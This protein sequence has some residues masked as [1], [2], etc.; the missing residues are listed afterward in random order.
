MTLNCRRCGERLIAGKRFCPACGASADFSCPSCGATI[1]PGFKY[2]PDCGAALGEGSQAPPE[3]RAARKPKRAA[4]GRPAAGGTRRPAQPKER[5]L[6]TVL[7]CDLVGSTAIAERLDPEEYHELLERY[8]A[9]A[10]KEIHRLGGMVT[11]MAGDG[12]M[13]LFG[14]PLAHEDA[15]ERAIRAA[16]SIRDSLQ[17]AGGQR[18]PAAGAG[19]NVRIGIH[20]G[21]VLLGPIGNDLRMDYTAIGDTTNVAARLQSVAEPGTILVSD[22]TERLVRGRFVLERAGDFELKG[23]TARVGAYVVRGLSRA[24][25]PMEVAAARGLT[26]FVGRRGEL[27]Q[28]S[29]CFDRLR[30]DLPQ[31]VALVGEAGSGKSRLLYEFKKLLSGKPVVLF[32][33]R[34]SSLSQ[35]VPFDGIN[36]MLRAYFGIEPGE[37]GEGTCSRMAGHLREL[38]EQAY[39]LH[40][41]LCRLLSLQPERQVELSPEELKRQMFDA[42]AA[43]V[44]TVSRTTPVVMILEDLQWMDEPSRELLELAVNRLEDA[45]VMIVVSHRPTYRPQWRTEAAFTSLNLRPLSETDAIAMMRAVAGESLP[46]EVERLILARAEGNPF[47]TEEMTRAMLEEGS[48]SRSAKGFRLARP[49]SELRVPDTVQELVA[50]RLDRLAPAAKRA[51]QVAAVLGRQFKRQALE[52]LIAGQGIDV[53]GA[54]EELCLAGLI[55][56]NRLLSNDEFRFGESLTQE[57]AYEGLLLKERRLLHERIGFMLEGEGRQGGADVAALSAYHFGRSDNLE[58]SLEASLRAAEEAEKIPSFPSAAAFYLQAWEAAEGLLAGGRSDARIV[59]P[60]ALR[61]ALGVSRMPVLYSASVEPALADRIALRGEELAGAMGDG[62]TQLYLRSLRGMLAIMSG[63]RERFEEGLQLVEEAHAA[64][65][66]EGLTVSAVRIS[67]GLAWNYL[68]DGRFDLARRTIDWVLEELE[69][70]GEAREA[71]DVYLGALWLRDSLNLYCDKLGEALAGAAATHELASRAGNRTIQS[72]AAGTVALAHFLKAQYREAKEWADRGLAIARTIGLGGATRTNAAVAL[73]AAIELGEGG[74]RS[75]YLR[76]LEESMGGLAGAAANSWLV[77]DALLCAGEIERAEHASRLLGEGGGQFRK[78]VSCLTRASVLSRLGASHWEEAACSFERAIE[79]ANA[80][81]SRSTQ[82]A[83]QIG[84]AELLALRGETES[85]MRLLAQAADTSRE[86][87]L[88]RYL[89]R[90][91]RA[92][93]EL[94]RRERSAQGGLG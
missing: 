49:V 57:V 14:A 83:A 69:K 86:L 81:G 11:Q 73:A 84:A 1:E 47:F 82:A 50:A 56:S 30:E 68:V 44:V 46:E 40:P 5:K 71:T 45:P 70:R 20:T 79:A 8:L 41:F 3:R 65:L 90:A 25:S 23:K 85:A 10:L 32:E 13:A 2:C 54:L 59:G 55:H 28:L 89:L 35:N 17:S 74:A 34:C 67:R 77:V 38:G 16:L 27:A 87:G 19:L 93:E 18:K 22:A 63:E 42:V 78:A 31:V 66:K 39:E 62:E 75:R 94:T 21:P 15:P 52:E 61:A 48:L 7:F 58:K 12:V 53:G 88:T 33:A 6:A 76:M 60:H 26:P 9:L 92:A 64:A 51:A 37:V 4:A 24:A 36:G 29:A 43:L 91:E 72:S 80:V